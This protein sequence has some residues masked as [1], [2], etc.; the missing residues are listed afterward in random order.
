MKAADFIH[1]YGPELPSDL[2][3]SMIER[4]LKTACL[5]V[6]A[7]LTTPTATGEDWAG[8]YWQ[9]VRQAQN[10]YYLWFDA[11][12]RPF[13]RPMPL[14]QHEWQCRIR[15]TLIC[16]CNASEAT[17]EAMFAQHCRWDALTLSAIETARRGAGRKEILL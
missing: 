6:D 13:D 3:F 10:L 4:D 16:L 17:R 1:Q 14:F 11:G 12:V 9:A 7:F 5:L 15:L 8:G 2:D